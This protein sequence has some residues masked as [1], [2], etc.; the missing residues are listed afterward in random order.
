[1]NLLCSMDW[2]PGFLCGFGAGGLL[3]AVAVWLDLRK[4]TYL[5]VDD[6]ALLFSPDG[7]GI[8]LPRSRMANPEDNVPDYIFV[9]CCLGA[10]LSAD[11]EWSHRVTQEAVEWFHARHGRPEQPKTGDAGG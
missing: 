6:A 11:A 5:P 10:R 3:L 7:M 1:M 2:M 8:M 4:R 9:A